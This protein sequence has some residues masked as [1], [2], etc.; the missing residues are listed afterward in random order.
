[1]CHV[2]LCVHPPPHSKSNLTLSSP[3][4]FI[5]PAAVPQAHT[6]VNKTYHNGS[7]YEGWVNENAKRHGHGKFVSARGDVFE[8]EWKADKRHGYGC[9]EWNSGDSFKGEWRN[10]FMHG[11]GTFTWT[12][13]K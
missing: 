2:C 5:A 11:E 3:V 8:G 6:Q 9:Y 12:S 4:A 13:G 1:M 10:G 7:T